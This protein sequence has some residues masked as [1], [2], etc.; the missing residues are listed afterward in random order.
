MP[1]TLVSTVTV[2]SGGAASIS[3]TGIPQTGKDLLA[4]ISIRTTAGLGYWSLFPQLN[5]QSSTAG[6]GI[7]GDGSSV[8]S[9]NAL[10]FGINGTNE[11]NTF[12]SAQIYVPNYTTS[13]AK[14]MSI[15]N[16]TERNATNANQEM[17]AVIFGNTTSAVTS[18]A[19]TGAGTLA[20]HTQVSLYIIS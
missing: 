5:S 16:V 18:L 17:S 15:D 7:Q 3:F 20:Q 14:T 6:K 8:G 4:L 11:T 9:Y 10:V 19:L 12:S 2:G 13:N 1:M